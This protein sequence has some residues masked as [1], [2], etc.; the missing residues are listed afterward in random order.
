MYEK[1][2]NETL[3]LSDD[4]NNFKNWNE[5]PTVTLATTQ[6]VVSVKNCTNHPVFKL[7]CLFR[8][9]LSTYRLICAS[10]W[11]VERRRSSSSLQTTLPLTLRSMCMTTGPWVSTGCLVLCPQ[12]AWHVLR[13]YWG[14]NTDSWRGH[15]PLDFAFLTTKQW[16]SKGYRGHVCHRASRVFSA[17]PPPC[18]STSYQNTEGRRLFTVA[19]GPV[20]SSMCGLL[21]KKLETKLTCSLCCMPSVN[22][23]QKERNLCILLSA[24]PQWPLWG[25]VCGSSSLSSDAL[26][27]VSP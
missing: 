10:S 7:R 4:L 2:H 21:K 13:K 27:S 9:S 8:A 1:C 22:R 17:H 14:H 5:K 11:W 18:E 12:L 20:G 24:P 25:C 16:R 19:A 23:V 3:T 6:N 26:P 15:T